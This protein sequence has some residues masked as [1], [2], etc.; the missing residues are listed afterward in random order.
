MAQCIQEASHHISTYNLGVV[1]S[2]TWC[3][4]LR[5][6]IILPHLQFLKAQKLDFFHFQMINMLLFLIPVIQRTTNTP[7]INK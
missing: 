1:S 3:V 7:E 6:D 2:L 5:G 4:Y